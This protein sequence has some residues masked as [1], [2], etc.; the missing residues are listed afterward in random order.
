MD[1][2]TI[3]ILAV[4][5][6]SMFVANRVLNVWT[7]NSKLYRYI[8][9]REHKIWVH[10][11]KHRQKFLGEV[12]QLFARVVVQYCSWFTSRTDLSNP[13][14]PIN[15]DNIP[16]R[17]GGGGVGG[18][19]T[20]QIPIRIVRRRGGHILHERQNPPSNG[21]NPPIEVRDSGNEPRMTIDAQK[22]GF[23]YLPPLEN[24]FSQDK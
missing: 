6:F 20:R 19:V 13:I 1:P 12:V 5:V 9:Y 16:P 4:F 2:T 3:G 7:L 22:D 15:F 14:N 21:Q 24:F 10:M 23:D 18:R 11:E 8:K 17:R